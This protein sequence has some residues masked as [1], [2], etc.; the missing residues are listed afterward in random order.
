MSRESRDRSLRELME[1]QSAGALLLSSPANFAWYTGGAD[2]RVDH[3][4]PVGVASLLL[5]GEGSHILTNNIEAPR[6]HEEQTPGIEVFEHPWHEEPGELLRELAGGAS[7]GTDVPSGFGQD[8]SA[9]IPPLRYVLDEDVIETYRRLGEDTCLAVS[10]AAGSLSPET[11]ELEAAGR[12]SPL[13]RRGRLPRRMEGSPSGRHGGLCF[14]RDHRDANHARGDRAGPGLRLEP[15]TRWCQ[16]RG[17]I[18]T[19]PGR[20]R[21]LDPLVTSSQQTRTT[22]VEQPSRPFKRCLRWVPQK[23]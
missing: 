7:V 23:W 15:L 20:S 2:N 5:T 19:R 17:N 12:L 22:L 6:M 11:D 14:P 18:R 4:D 16:G 10:E 9:E 1:E 3:G 8:L 21:S 13:L